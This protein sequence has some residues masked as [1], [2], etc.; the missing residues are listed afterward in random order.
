[1]RPDDT[2]HVTT[3]QQIIGI[4][5]AAAVVVV[6]FIGLWTVWSDWKKSWAIEDLTDHYYMDRDQHPREH[7][8]GWQD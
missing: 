7:M 4:L 2:W 8:A 6:I 3:D 5:I 1:M